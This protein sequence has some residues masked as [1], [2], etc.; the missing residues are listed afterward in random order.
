MVEKINI[1]KLERRLSIL[2]EAIESSINGIIITDMKGEITYV[3]PSFLEMFEYENEEEVLGSKAADLFVTDEVQRFSDVEIIIDSTKGETEEFKVFHKDESEFYVE[4]SSDNIKDKNGNIIGRMASFVDISERKLLENRLQHSQ[5]LEVI[6]QIMTGIAH[7]M[8]TPLA[9]ILTRLKILEEELITINNK[10]LIEQIESV[11]SNIEK[12]SEII[13]KLLGFSR[14]IDPDKEGINI[15]DI[16]TD[17]MSFVITHAQKLNI[18]IQTDFEK[19]IPDL[20]V[21]KNKME[22]VFLNIVMN[23][24]D[25]MTDGGKLTISTDVIT[26]HRKKYLQIMFIDTGT[27][28]SDE[29]QKNIFNPFFTTKPSGKGTGLGM[30]IS[31]EIIE[32]ING[33]IQVNSIENKG[34]ELIILI[35]SK[36]V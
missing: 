6:G 24:F 18:K 23:A 17:I 10:Y 21:I 4:V 3:N 13:K 28:M 31:K 33:T 11:N 12:I 32:E 25:A 29:A 34:T 27:G 20:Y 14:S 19:N 26:L 30:Y 22:Q 8:N 35:P 9:V 15:N 1:K 36:K 16:L 5:K 2:E 7:Q